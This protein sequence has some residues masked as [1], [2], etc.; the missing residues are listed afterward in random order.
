MPRYQIFIENDLVSKLDEYIRRVY[1]HKDIYIITDR[2]V[3][4]LYFEVI[5][6]RLKAFNVYW[7]VIEAGE[8]S[9]SMTVYQTVIKNLIEKGIRRNHLMVALGGGVVG[10]L[11]GFVAATLYR[12]LPLI[13]I[14]TTLLAQVDSS[15]GGKVGINLLEGKNL[16]G[17]F[18]Q[19]KAVLIDPKFLE[20]LE[21]D[22]YA[23]GIAEMVKCGLIAD[24]KLYE[25]FLKNDVVTEKEIARAVMVKRKLVLKDPF[26]QYER[27]LLNFGHTF[28]H[29]IEK[30]SNYEIKH[31]HAISHGMLIA[32]K[33]GM[34]R[35]ITPNI[36]D[37]VKQVLN[38]FKLVV[39][40]PVDY[41]MYMDDLSL[42]KKNLAD[43]FRFIYITDIGKSFVGRLDVSKL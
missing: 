5:A 29:A 22:E 20:T 17:S 18:Y 13:Q 42:D 2:N 39:D 34:K 33:L 38:R 14:P 3:Y 28:G 1:H 4:K 12:G 32:I 27:M 6:A 19:P 24:K 36:Y 43:G 23:N 10:D 25:F 37:E 11:A 26:D 8:K 21:A 41:M 15:V 16:L 40:E 9:K 31:G 7:E 30:K 35:G